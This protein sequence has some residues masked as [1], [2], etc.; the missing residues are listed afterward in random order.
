[1]WG[2]MVVYSQHSLK[3]GVKCYPSGC[4]WEHCTY[5]RCDASGSWVID[6]V[7]GRSV[8]VAMFSLL[9]TLTAVRNICRRLKLSTSIPLYL[10]NIKYYV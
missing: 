3:I 1:M 6:L 4:S 2:K 7:V 5:V 10:N 8:S 9:A